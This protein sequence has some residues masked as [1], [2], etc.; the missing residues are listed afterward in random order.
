LVT[1]KLTETTP[2]PAEVGPNRQAVRS[3]A[4]GDV[5]DGEIGVVEEDHRG[6]LRVG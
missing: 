4:A 6:S 2:A 1:Q 5:A 3:E